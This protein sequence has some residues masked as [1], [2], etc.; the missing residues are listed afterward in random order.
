[1]F[2]VGGPCGCRGLRSWVGGGVIEELSF[3]LKVSSQGREG[4]E[5]GSHQQAAGWPRVMD[6][7]AR[8]WQGGRFVLDAG[9]N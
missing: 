8:G 5:L 7:L 3:F 2:R 9:M 6:T 1:M 4:M